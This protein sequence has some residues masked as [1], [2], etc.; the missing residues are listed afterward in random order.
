M[1]RPL[2]LVTKPVLRSGG[3]G[4]SPGYMIMGRY[5]DTYSSNSLPQNSK[6]S[7]TPVNSSKD[8]RY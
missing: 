5:L 8:L 6:L 4:P 7:I 3:E 1:S 2:M